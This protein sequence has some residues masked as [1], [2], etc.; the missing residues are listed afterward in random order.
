MGRENDRVLAVGEEL[1]L[2]H[3]DLQQ[4][5]TSGIINIF[6]LWLLQEEVKWE[7][8]QALQYGWLVSGLE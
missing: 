2:D 8:T 5:M 7:N 4:C 6:T 1:I 3:Q